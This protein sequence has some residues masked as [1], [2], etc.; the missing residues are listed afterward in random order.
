MIRVRHRKVAAR[1]HCAIGAMLD[2]RCV[3]Q[4]TDKIQPRGF[5]SAFFGPVLSEDSVP[6]TQNDEN[7]SV[8]GPSKTSTGIEM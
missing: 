7:H 2:S 3:V 1:L 6:T 4:N 8:T 5:G